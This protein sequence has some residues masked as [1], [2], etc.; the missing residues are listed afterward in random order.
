VRQPFSSEIRLDSLR[1]D[2]PR[3]ASTTHDPFDKS[4]ELPGPGTSGSGLIPTSSSSDRSGSA[5]RAFSNGRFME[6]NTIRVRIE[7]NSLILNADNRKVK[8]QIWDSTGRERFWSMSKTS[9][10]NGCCKS[11]CQSV[12]VTSHPTGRLS[13]RIRQMDSYAGSG[14]SCTPASS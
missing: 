2:D 3:Q 10:G 14:S 8:L 7:F 6:E 13:R 5:R 9:H 11:E 4:R 1:P 12:S